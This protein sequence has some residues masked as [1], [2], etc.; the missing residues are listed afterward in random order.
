MVHMPSRGQGSTTASHWGKPEKAKIGLHVRHHQH[1]IW[2]RK[3]AKLVNC[4]ISD[5]TAILQD[6]KLR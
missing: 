4:G 2:S 3:G 6:E 1:D 5:E